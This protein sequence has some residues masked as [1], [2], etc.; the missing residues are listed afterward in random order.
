MREAIGIPVTVKCRIGID[1]Q[2]TEQSLD[3]FA[4]LMVGAGADGALCPCAQGLAQGAVAEGEPRDPAARLSAR[5]S[6]GRAARAVSGDHQWRHQDDEGGR[7]AP[8]GHLAA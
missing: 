5:P 4:D 8:R 7:R 2:D 1:E 6:A 3:R